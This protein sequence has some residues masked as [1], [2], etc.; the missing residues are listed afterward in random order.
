MGSAYCP[1]HV[2]EGISRILV[3][4]NSNNAATTRATPRPT[5][6]AIRT[7][8]TTRSPTRTLTSSVS[9]SPSS[10]A[11]RSQG[12]NTS[13]ARGSLS[14]SS[15]LKS[16][17]LPSTTRPSAGRGAATGT[18]AKRPS[19]GR[20]AATGPSTKRLS[21]GRAAATGPSTKRLSTG[22][23]AATGPSTKRLSAGRAAATGPS[24]KRPAT[25]RPSTTRPS[26]RLAAATRLS[27]TRPEPSS[28]PTVNEDSLAPE[29]AAPVSTTH[30]SITAIIDDSPV[31]LAYSGE[32]VPLPTLA[33]HKPAPT[34]ASDDETKLFGDLLALAPSVFEGLE[35]GFVVEFLADHPADQQQLARRELLF[36]EKPPGMPD[37]AEVLVGVTK[38]VDL[39]PGEA[40]YVV[41][42]PASSG[43]GTVEIISGF[44]NRTLGGVI[45]KCDGFFTLPRALETVF[46]DTEGRLWSTALEKANI[47]RAL[48]K[49]GMATIFTVEDSKINE[50]NLPGPADLNQLIH[51]GLLYDPDWGDSLCLQ[52]RG[53]TL[54]ITRNG[55]DIL[56]NDVLIIK[57]N[58]IAKNCVIHYL[59]EIPPVVTCTVNSS[60][61]STV[62]VP[63]VAVLGLLVASLAGYVWM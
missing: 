24:T 14:S 9:R 61:G 5:V 45:K 44:G 30:G 33:D 11:R 3:R 51:D 63:K 6:S 53:G 46:G 17:A 42:N 50:T 55:N 41:S 58:V 52:T 4:Q 32:V 49:N 34:L 56:V 57:A 12:S 10:S 29:D 43:D 37:I 47:L 60:A 7:T 13:S 28:F 18:S 36:A 16:L 25:K 21:T 39:G 2:Q 27:T 19:T 35:E 23:A 59:E 54:L 26:A 20:A 38:Y 15:R 40:A 8:T 31:T 62:V 1:G 48:S 22:R